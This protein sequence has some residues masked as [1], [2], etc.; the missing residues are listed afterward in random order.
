MSKHQTEKVHDRGIG[1]DC[2]DSGDVLGI[3][4]DGQVAAAKAVRT[5]IPDLE[6]GAELMAQAIRSGGNLV[7]AAAGSSGM[8]GMTDGLELAPTFGIPVDRITILRA[9]DLNDMVGLTGDVEDNVDAAI[10]D[11]Q[12]IGANDCV[13]CL[14]AS[15]N[16]PYP[17]TVM[18]V[19]RK[20]G[21]STIGISNNKNTPL[22]ADS[23]VSVLLPT[24]PEVIA[25]STR[26]GA[27]TA[28][29]I[30]L[31]MMSSLMGVKLGHV[32]DGL[33]VSVV[34]NNEKLFK[35]AENIVVALTKCTDEVAKEKIGQA[36]GN[37]KL[38]VLLASGVKDNAEAQR[39][40]D[41]AD[42]NLRIALSMKIPG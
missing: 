3:L 34:A 8:I 21:A 24:P 33:M 12:V 38:A 22:L 16:T 1:L 7:Y 26:L 41:R 37:V 25:G 40:L 27:A 17:V 28:Q 42:Q 30:A 23:D 10:S 29:K 2:L 11:A 14:S 36:D 13:I 15:G 35:R 4:L 32:M 20:L 9:G 5:A 19:A 39:Y 6:S 31:N 18:E